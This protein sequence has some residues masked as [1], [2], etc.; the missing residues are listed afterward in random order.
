M[1]TTLFLT[2]FIGYFL[3]LL[4]VGWW[5]SRGATNDTY[6][7]AG[8][9]A[10]WLLVSFGMI[11]TSLSGVTF[12]SVPGWVINANMTYLMMVIGFMIGY[13]II[14]FVLLPLYYKNNSV[15][16]Y[17]VL[18][19]RF[20][21]QGYLT[22]SGFFLLS[23]T[24][25]ASARMF[26]V[27]A[28]LQFMIFDHI[29]I[30]GIGPVPF[31]ATACLLLI[32]IAL[33]SGN[34]GMGTIVITD[35]L[36]TLFMLI[37]VGMAIYYIAPA[38]VPSGE[39][40]WEHI[41]AHEKSEIWRAEGPKSW[42]RQLLAGASIALAMTG[43]DQDMMQK[44]LT[45]K[46]V[47]DAQKNVLLLGLNLIWVNILFLGLGVLLYEYVLNH[48]MLDGLGASD[49]LFATVVMQPEFPTALGMVFFL[50][51]LAAAFSSADSALAALTTSFSHDFLGI[52]ASGSVQKRKR[53]YVGFMALVLLTM[54]GIW[55]NGNDSIIN[56]LFTL[57]GYTY[58]P[59][60]GMFAFLLFSKRVP[61]ATWVLPIALA[62]PLLSYGLQWY[63]QQRNSPIGF[64]LLLINAAITYLLLLL[65]AFTQKRVTE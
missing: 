12:I 28:V 8:H 61:K 62:S 48:G 17:A 53:V 2:L 59:L 22:A 44:Q 47:G 34:G 35:T 26:I 25:G 63:M 65:A 20:G 10:P 14:A 11:G 36:Q 9:K 42:W 27:T 45:V 39:G 56:T 18:E 50:G 49:D 64:E 15:S 33:Y 19:E 21:R 51:L 29:H 24:V 16:I 46:R 54:I 60:L 43:L 55:L 40:V 57:T 6:Y 3:F 41:F 4:A 52:G 7:S 30:P 32:C 38:V 58:G 13:T 5:T 37:A 23:R 1:N 31:W